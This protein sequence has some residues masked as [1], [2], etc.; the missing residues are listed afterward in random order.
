MASIEAL[1]KAKKEQ[2]LTLDELATRS[3]VAKRTI[4]D[5]LQGKTKNPRVD[6]MQALERAL[7]LAPSFTEADQ[8]KGAGNAPIALSD[9]DLNTLGRINRAEDVLGEAYVDAVLDLLD[10][11]VEKKLNEGK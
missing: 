2:K 5:I 6:T 11:N 9:R 8:A 3:G 1:K 7:G 4:E 10:M